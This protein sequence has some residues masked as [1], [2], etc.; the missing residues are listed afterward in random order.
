M[1][2]QILKE[3]AALDDMLNIVIERSSGDRITDVLLREMLETTDSL[4]GLV[5]GLA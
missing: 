3:I 5:E 4:K 2:E 1:K